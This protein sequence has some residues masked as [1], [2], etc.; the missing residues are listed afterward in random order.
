MVTRIG[1]AAFQRDGEAH[2]P[3]DYSVSATVQ[4]SVSLAPS[5]FKLTPAERERQEDTARAQVEGRR[6]Q[7]PGASC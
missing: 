7:P 2:G 1:Q 4:R 5:L 3:R 6:E